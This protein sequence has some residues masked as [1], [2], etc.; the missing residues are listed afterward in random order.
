MKQAGREI[1]EGRQPSGRK[2]VMRNAPTRIDGEPRLAPGVEEMWGRDTVLALSKVSCHLCH[3]LGW[4]ELNCRFD[5]PCYC[6]LRSVFRTCFG[7]YREFRIN[8]GR[9]GTVNLNYCPTGRSAK[10][11]YSRKREEYLADFELI[12]KRVLN[13]ELWRVFDLHFLQGC[14]W[15]FCAQYL[16]MDRGSFF[17]AVYRIES[18]LGRVYRELQPYG[19]WPLAAYFS[20][21]RPS[22]DQLQY[23]SSAAGGGYMRRVIPDKLAVRWNTQFAVDRHFAAG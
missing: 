1:L 20:E 15:R 9:A 7:R 23:Q 12:A 3:G 5:A 13:R 8:Q 11:Y 6:V 16:R 19:L 10:R 2:W 14:E 22:P 18:K 17:H 4:M 21:V